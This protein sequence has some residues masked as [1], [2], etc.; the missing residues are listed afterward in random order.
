MDSVAQCAIM[1]AIQNRNAEFTVQELYLLWIGQNLIDY[2]YNG[3][4]NKVCILY[5]WLVHLYNIVRE[6]R[7]GIQYK[8]FISVEDDDNDYNNTIGPNRSLAKLLP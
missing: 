3:L 1:N 7:E 5:I 2:C 4:Y 6:G 8:P